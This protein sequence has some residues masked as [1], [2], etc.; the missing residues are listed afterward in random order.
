MFF[1]RC[2]LF[3][4]AAKARKHS[5]EKK[6]FRLSIFICIMKIYS[7]V[8][9]ETPKPRLRLRIFAQ[10]RVEVEKWRK[11]SSNK[12]PVASY[13]WSIHMLNSNFTDFIFEGKKNPQTHEIN[14]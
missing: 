8:A 10:R 7:C 12:L 13:L 9:H 1:T 3:T 14:D 11:L 2:V 6:K 5:G 4:A